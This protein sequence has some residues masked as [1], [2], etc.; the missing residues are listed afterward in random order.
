MALHVVVGPM[1][2]GKSSRCLELARRHRAIGRRVLMLKPELDTRDHLI[3]THDGS[4]A[5]CTRL[6]RLASAAEL[7]EYDATSMILIDEAQFFEDLVPAVR[8][9]LLDK[10]TV[11]VYGLDGDGKQRRFGT[12]LDL[13]PLADSVEKLLGLCQLCGAPAPFTVTEEHIPETQILIGGEE[14]YTP[15]CRF[16]LEDFGGVE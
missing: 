2:S 13:V 10:K 11:H 9:F 16:H 14:I 5:Q 15:V 1:F 8:R 3:A 12:V 4:M 6:D 7:S